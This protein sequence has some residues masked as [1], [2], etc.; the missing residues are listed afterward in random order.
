MFDDFMRWFGTLWEGRRLAYTVGVLSCL[1][2]VVLLLVA[3]S[4]PERR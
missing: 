3:R 2:G 1:A 4:L